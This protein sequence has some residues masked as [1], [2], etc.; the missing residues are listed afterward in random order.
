MQSDLLNYVPTDGLL[1]ERV[2]LVTGAAMG[3]GK[4]VAV[5]YARFGATVV[6]VDKQ[7]LML[8]A[9]YD[10]IVEAGYPEPVICK[11]DLAEATADAYS[12][13]ALMIKQELGRLDGILLNAAWLG[14]FMSIRQQDLELWTKMLQINLHAN[15][16]LVRACLPLLE[17]SPDAAIVF[18]TDTTDRA[19]YG[20]FGVS[21]AAMNG[22][23]DILAQE[24]D[25]KPFIRVN[26]IHT[27][28]VRTSMRVLNFP[29][30]HADTNVR[31][32]AV[33]GP[34]LY[35]MG[36]DATQR[37]GEALQLGKVPTDFQWTGEQV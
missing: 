5:Q 21:K 30:E 32:E 12:S 11:L 28:P 1:R 22:F 10:E 24:Y 3:I 13:L 34:Y 18:S 20:G 15:F 19:Y 35:F 33:V 16:L 37:T 14:A 6:L 27:G 8:D 9:V 7:E 29:G 23:C 25:D 17:K 26:R 2:I 31:P 4:A 36:P